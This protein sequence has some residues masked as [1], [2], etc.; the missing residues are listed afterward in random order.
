[1]ILTTYHVELSDRPQA[2][3]SEKSLRI[4]N[5]LLQTQKETQA[6]KGFV[7]RLLLVIYT[8]REW[9]NESPENKIPGAEVWFNPKKAHNILAMEK[10]ILALV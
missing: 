6:L 4:V 2:R 8:A 9:K 1:L 5:Q 10:E 3:P 7:Q